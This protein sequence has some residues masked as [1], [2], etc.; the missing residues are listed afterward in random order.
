M[1]THQCARRVAHTRFSA[2]V[3]VVAQTDGKREVTFAGKRVLVT[4]ASRGIGR[5]LTMA[6]VAEGA[7]VAASGRSQKGLAETRVLS[8]QP[9]MVCLCP[10]D[11]RSSA[12]LQTIAESALEQLGSIDVLM[13]VAGVWHNAERKYQG[14]LAADTPAAEI[15]EVLDVG[16]K[17]AFHLTRLVLPGMIQAAGGKIVFVSCG[18]AGP[19]EAVGWVHY[20]VANKAIEALVAGLAAELRPHNVQV[21]AVA[22]WFVATE[23]V[24]T[25]YPD[26]AAS[27]LSPSE[28][29]DMA[30]FLAC[31]R[32]D[33]VSGQTIELRSRADF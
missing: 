4:G 21:N 29:V 15:D 22:P 27:A 1:S 16:V 19:S 8:G 20:Y 5:A 23:A 26:Q 14:P 9:D 33:H 17:G 32:S 3:V 13:N 6:L 18:F 11:L 24:Q 12:D 25:F 2:T 7:K 30:M 31:D 10:G 28:V